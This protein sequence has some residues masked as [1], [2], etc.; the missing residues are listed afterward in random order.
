MEVDKSSGPDQQLHDLYGFINQVNYVIYEFVKHGYFIRGGV[1]IG[2]FYYDESIVYGSAHVNAYLLE[3]KV[4]VSPRVVLS[5]DLK[6]Y[7]TGLTTIFTVNPEY[8]QDFFWA[9]KIM[10]SNNYERISELKIAIYRKLYFRIYSMQKVLDDRM[11]RQVEYYELDF[12][13]DKQKQID[14]LINEG[15]IEIDLSELDEIKKMLLK[16]FKKALIK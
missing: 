7:I 14:L 1:D 2:D 15:I 6:E 11:K 8:N 4:S 5:D 3:S 13:D 16:I 10:L 9:L 12:E